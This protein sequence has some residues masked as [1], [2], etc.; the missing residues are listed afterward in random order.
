MN[1]LAFDSSTSLL[2]IALLQDEKISDINVFRTEGINFFFLVDDLL[3]TQ[4]MKLVDIDAIC[5]GLG[6]GS[7]TGLR[8]SGA[9]AKG[10]SL[11]LQKPLIGISSFCS[12]AYQTA[13]MGDVVV[14]ENAGRNLVY[15]GY[16]HLDAKLNIT[17][18]QKETLS[19]LDTFLKTLRTEPIFTGESFR[20]MQ[21]IREKFPRAFI[22][23]FSVYPLA[24]FLLKEAKRR[25]EKE[26]FTDI[27]KLFPLYLYSKVCQIRGASAFIKNPQKHKK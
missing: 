4:N 7:F 8:V 24:R 6:P 22:I 21:D 26:L 13:I 5:V 18:K 27:E 1:I 10:F 12:I 25:F 3:K 14:L 20:F 19:S 2:S 11:A 15:A 16:F 9:I 23:P 17:R